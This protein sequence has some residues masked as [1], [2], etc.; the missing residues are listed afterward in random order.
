MN[1]EVTVDVTAATKTL[2]DADLGI[3]QVIKNAACVITL[4]AAAAGK[5]VQVQLGGVQKSGSTPGSGDNKS[6]GV[7]VRPAGAD[8]MTGDNFTPAAAKGATLLA[9][10]GRVGD[11][12][13]FVSGAATWYIRRIIAASAAVVQREA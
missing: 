10:N 12:L 1:S 7:I 11:R 2:T 13:E 8:T 6:S 3:T 4:P 5:F 9:A